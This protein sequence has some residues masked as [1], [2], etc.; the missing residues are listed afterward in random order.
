LSAGP[1]V[2]FGKPETILL[3]DSIADIDSL[4]EFL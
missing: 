3:N 4:I 2:A 1:R